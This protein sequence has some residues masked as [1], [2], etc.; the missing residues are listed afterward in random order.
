MYTQSRKIAPSFILAIVVGLWCALACA[1]VAYGQTNP[2]PDTIDNIQPTNDSTSLVN[3]LA[4]RGIDSVEGFFVEIINIILVFARP[5][6]V[7]FI[8]YAGF[9]YVTAQGDTTKLTT[10]RNALLWSV[11]GGVVVF[12]ATVIMEVIRGTVEGF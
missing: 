12:G 5:I 9:L 7:L 11:I 10:A 8:M 3:P 6:V 2:N 4:G 1:S